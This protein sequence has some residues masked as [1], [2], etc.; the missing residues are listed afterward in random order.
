MLVVKV[1]VVTVGADGDAAAYAGAELTGVAFPLLKRIA[2]EEHLI[3]LQTDLGEDGLFGIGD[4]LEINPL[5]GQPGFHLFGSGGTP[6]VLLEGLKIDGEA[7]VAPVAINLYLVIAGYPLG[8]LGEVFKNHVRVS[9]EIMRAIGMDEDA[10]FVVA[11][12]R[13]TADVL[14]LLDNKA[15][16]AMLGA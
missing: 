7:P 5:L 15:P 10:L 1:A 4:G 14:P 3:P 6:D 12:M 16:L 2:L 8:K 13:I 9:P 11:V